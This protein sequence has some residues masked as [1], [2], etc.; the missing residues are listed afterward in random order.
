MDQRPAG[1][2][3]FVS[4]AHDDDRR[5][6][7][8]L[9]EELQREFTAIADRRLNVFLDQDGIPTAQRWQQTIRSALRTSS[10]MIAMLTE[11]Y[12]ASDW[13]AR[14]YEFFVT[15]EHDH[16]LEEGAARSI[17]RIFPVMP[18]GPPAEGDL[19]AEQRRRRLD[20]AERQ[21]IDLRGAEGPD[22]TRE[23]NRLA[24]DVHEAL[25]RLAGSSPAVRSPA[26]AEED[27]TEHPQVTSG[28]V[29][30]GDRFVSL[31]AEAVNVTV[32]GWTNESLAES[33]DAALKLKRSRHGGRAFWRSLRIVFLKDDLLELIRDEHD[34]QFPDTETAL[35][36][37]RQNAGYG[38]RS[39]S[40]LLLRENQPHRFTLHEY[41]HI[42]PFTGTLFDMPDGRRIVQVVIRPPRRSAS[43]H[44]F[45]EF[46]D[47][48]DQY[49]GAAFN[50]IVDLSHTY[51]EV[52]PIGEPDDD[53]VFQCTE[54]R[55]RNRVL[56]D[57]S[58]AKGWLPL[59]LVVPWWES[60]G[61]A[62]PLLQFRTARNAGRELGRVSHPAGHITQED[63][64]RI[65]DRSE[66][67]ATTF[68]LPTHAPMIAARRR[69]AL[70]L[71]ADLS[72][73]VTFARNM[74]YYHHD[75][76]HLFFWV[77]DC[78]LPARFQF[79][80]DAEMRPYTL[81]ELLAIRENQVFEYAARLCR[82][83]EVSR[84]N[85]ERMARI[86]A[87]NLTAHGH[88]DLAETLLVHL[89]G[90][91]AASPEPLNELTER[92]ERTRRFDRTGVGERRVLGLSG[93]E[94]RE[95]FSGI[96]PLYARLGV[97]GAVEYLETLEAD[98]TRGTAVGRLAAAY[99][100]LDVMSALPL[101]V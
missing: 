95:F 94:Y 1:Y 89:R 60:R 88:H 47:R 12:L 37:R 76:E 73:E 19:S 36:R 28:Y 90:D 16:S 83:S 7:Q 62:V 53:D 70:E 59:V 50:D 58:G 20:A 46:A 6:I 11:N 21:G 80:A 98:E 5:V 75:K 93:L 30:T 29:N 52:L 43:D 42:P 24:R 56:Q 23:V 39:L 66:R 81:E 25:E 40:A 45:L 33:L 14:E 51:D 27:D 69:V 64:R 4:Y 68:P 17:P 92:A 71:G 91:R 54:A 38:R 8:R 82:S 72:Q 79:P 13:C 100:D 87:A 85:L 2:D 77:F 41:G 26:P 22:F 15:T 34:A 3:V 101:E 31:L 63:Y 61:T 65:E 55:F 48:T 97:P 44:L 49:F 74:R 67:A 78:R 99:A 84:Q 35:R 10:V 32:V 96:L 86:C 18:A 57:G 9:V